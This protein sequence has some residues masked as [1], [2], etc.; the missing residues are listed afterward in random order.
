MYERV[1]VPTDGSEIGEEGAREGLELA[2]EL[3]IPAVSLYI[4]DISRYDEVVNEDN[5][6]RVR[7]D[8]KNIGERALRRIRK[9]AHELDVDIETKLLLGE[10]YDR[11][12]KE[13]DEG[14]IIY[15][16]SHGASGFSEMFFGSTTERV[17]KHANCTVA[18][19]KPSEK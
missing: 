2:S 10:P 3:D 15:M 17:M 9:M 14:D 5:K 6:K 1:I 12:T 11:I 13:A 4:L 18:V 16:S 19:V 8:S 7:E